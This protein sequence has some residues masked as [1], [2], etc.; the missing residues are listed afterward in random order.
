L[1]RG[2]AEELGQIRNGG[3]GMCGAGAPA[4]ERAWESLGMAD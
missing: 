3:I 1:R 2:S 4:R